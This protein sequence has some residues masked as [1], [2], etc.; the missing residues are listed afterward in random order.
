MLLVG[1]DAAMAFRIWPHHQEKKALL[2]PCDLGID[3]IDGIG[4][5]VDL[6]S[7]ENLNEDLLLCNV[8]VWRSSLVDANI[9]VKDKV[10]LSHV[11]WQ[12]RFRIQRKKQNYIM[13][14]FQKRGG[15]HIY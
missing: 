13:T 10:R 12:L 15:L 2:T 6:K 8:K 14:Q 1:G 5:Q 4:R 7:S 9:E 11:T 3:I